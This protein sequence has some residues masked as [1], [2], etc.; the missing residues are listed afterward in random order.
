[1]RCHGQGPLVGG[2]R[3]VRRSA[4]NF[5]DGRVLE[6]HRPSRAYDSYLPPTRHEGGLL[7]LAL[8]LGPERPLEPAERCE[9]VARRAEFVQ[10]RE[11]SLVFAD[12]QQHGRI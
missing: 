7:A 2:D 11:H 10:N 3:P 6:R 8:D 4:E 1:M 9:E 12:A 5:S